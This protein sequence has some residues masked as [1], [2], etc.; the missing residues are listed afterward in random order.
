MIAVVN[1]SSSSV[2]VFMTTTTSRII[3]AIE[4][5]VATTSTGAIQ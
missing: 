1:H 4:T 5:A 3:T 2:S